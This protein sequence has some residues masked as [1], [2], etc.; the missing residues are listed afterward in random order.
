MN[1]LEDVQDLLSR[2]PLGDGMDPLKLSGPMSLSVG[3]RDAYIPG[4]GKGVQTPGVYFFFG[5]SEALLYVGSSSNLAQRVGRH[6]EVLTNGAAKANDDAGQG[7]ESVYTV[8][9][10]N[11]FYREALAIEYFVIARLR[12]GNNKHPRPDWNS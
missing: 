9:L 10:A 12:P 3:Y 1:Y 5:P 7:A 8:C 4:Q 2:Y 6:F 11:E